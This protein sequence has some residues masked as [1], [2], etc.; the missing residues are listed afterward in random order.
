MLTSATDKHMHNSVKSGNLD[1][2]RPAYTE[3]MQS[4]KQT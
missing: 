3:P 1:Y 2:E 4:L